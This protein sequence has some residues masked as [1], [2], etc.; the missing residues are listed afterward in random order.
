MVAIPQA[1]DCS[2]HQGPFTLEQARALYAGG[3][4]YAGLGAGPGDY[5]AFTQRQGLPLSNAGIVLF[6]YTFAELEVESRWGMTP[7][8]WVDHAVD[9]AKGLPITE[10]FV[11]VEDSAHGLTWSPEQR[12]GYYERYFA[13][14]WNGWNIDASYYGAAWYTNGYLARSTRLAISPYTGRRRRLWNGSKYDSNPDVTYLPPGFT[15]ADV[16]IEQYAGTTAI[17]LPGGLTFTADL[18]F[19]YT[20]LAAQEDGMTPAEKTCFSIAGGDYGRLT[21]DY[22]KLVA[23]GLLPDE[24]ITGVDDL[25]AAAVKRF[26]LIELAATNAEATVA[27]LGA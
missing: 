26:H 24:G 6:A 12:L 18:D 11:D 16:A 10:W 15:A 21:R 5:G 8:D 19:V 20:P 1:F 27:A 17:D 3:A 4:R 13:R 23:A 25:N 22:A 14:F 2:N 7:E 9:S